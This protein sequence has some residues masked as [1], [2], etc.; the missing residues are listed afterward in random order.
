MPTLV[1]TCLT[2][3]SYVYFTRRTYFSGTPCSLKHLQTS[4]RGTLLYVVPR[5][6]NSMCSSFCISWC[7]S[8][9]CLSANMASVVHLP[10][11]KPNCSTPMHVCSLGLL[12]IILT[13][14]FLAW[15][16]YLLDASIIPTILDTPLCLKIGAITLSL[17]YSGVFSCSEIFWNIP[18]NISSPSSPALLQI[19]TA[20]VRSNRLSLCHSFHRPVCFWC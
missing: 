9:T 18:N 4:C 2:E 13:P 5:S 12:S 19:C 16:I 20:T 8:I 15:H 14:I 11:M 6:K 7:F 3:S 1:L 17:H 10:R